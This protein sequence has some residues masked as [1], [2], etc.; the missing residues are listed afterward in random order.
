MILFLKVMTDASK[1]INRCGDGWLPGSSQAVNCW[2]AYETV[3]T[4]HFYLLVGGL[5]LPFGM[6]THFLSSGGEAG[7]ENK[8]GVSHLKGH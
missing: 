3:R 1:N 7:G 5:P 2:G 8:N 4:L 6:G